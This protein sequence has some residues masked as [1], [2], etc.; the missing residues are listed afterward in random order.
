MAST[1]VTEISTLELLVVVIL[2]EMSMT[3]FILL[4]EIVERLHNALRHCTLSGASEQH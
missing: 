2:V 4:L 1:R 3:R